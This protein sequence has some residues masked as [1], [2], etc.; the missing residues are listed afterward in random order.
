MILKN[1]FKTIVSNQAGFT[2]LETT[3]ILALVSV[4]L[5]SVLSLSVESSR[6]QTANRESLIAYELAREGIE[7]VRTVRDTNLLRHQAWNQDITGSVGGQKYI[8][9]YENYTPALVGDISQAKLYNKV[10][11]GV[12][13]GFYSHSSSGNTPSIF[14]RLIT[15][16]SDSSSAATSSVDCLIQWEDAGYIN[17]YNLKTVLY[18]WF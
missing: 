1:F 13:T 14:N 12:E 2:L 5:V 17:T 9:D 4:G 10:A 18:N 15:I 8:I 16:T 6:A 11:A 7:L 3:V